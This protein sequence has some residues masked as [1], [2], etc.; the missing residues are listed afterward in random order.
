MLRRCSAIFLVLWFAALGMGVLEVLHDWCHDREDAL[1]DQADRAAGRPV[2]PH[3]HD[4]TN[5]PVHAQLHMPLVNA[6]PLPMLALLGLLLARL[7]LP[8][9]VSRVSLTFLGP[10]VCRGPPR[11][12]T[13]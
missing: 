10:V 3:E 11:C 12:C 13:F 4:E 6:A 2:L 7:A 1:V 5:C 9:P 8:P